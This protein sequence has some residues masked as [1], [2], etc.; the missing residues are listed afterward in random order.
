MGQ[1]KNGTGK[2]GTGNKTIESSDLLPCLHSS[3]ALNVLCVYNFVLYR[4]CL[5][6]FFVSFFLFF[7][8]LLF[9]KIVCM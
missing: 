6:R 4:T 3:L 8:S 2:T 7:F 5:F 9:F 1:R